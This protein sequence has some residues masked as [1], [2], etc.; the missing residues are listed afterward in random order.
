MMKTVW[1]DTKEFLEQK[2][3]ILPLILTATLSYGFMAVT[4]TIGI[5]DTASERFFQEGLE[6][7]MGRWVLFLINKVFSFAEFAPFIT[8]VLGVIFMIISVTLWCV[9]FKRI[10]GNKIPILGYTFFSCIFISAPI[11]SE[12]FTYYTH[13]GIG[14]A[15]GLAAVGAI[16]FTEGMKGPV[17]KRWKSLII[18]AL[19]AA[20]A[21]GCYESMV[22]V[23]IMGI[24]MAYLFL[25]KEESGQHY[26]RRLLWW[27]FG[28]GISVILLML[29]RSLLI[30]II[31]VVFQ[32]EK[33]ILVLPTRGIS[34]AF[35]WVNGTKSMGEFTMVLKRF[36]LKYYI[37]ALR[38][39]PI[40]M[41]VIAALILMI[42][43]C[44]QTIRYRKPVLLFCGCAILLIP[45]V[46][47]LIEAQVTPYRASQYIPLVCGFAVL[48]L[49]DMIQE[50]AKGRFF[51]PLWYVAVIWMTVCTFNQC[52]E[53]NKWFYVDHLKYEDAKNTMNTIAYELENSYD[54]E[55]PIIFVGH[56]RVPDGMLRD[57]GLK[58]NAKEFW[59][60]RACSDILDPHLKEKYY[61]ASGYY[62]LA[63]T[64][65]LSV[66]NWGVSAFD[67]TN[68]E[69][70][71]FLKMH[72][73]EF[74]METDLKRYEQAEK[75]AEDR[76]MPSWPE[77]G[78]IQDAEEYIIVKLGALKE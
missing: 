31:K 34:E 29:V 25:C 16:A 20:T 53:M 72:G 22:I 61:T 19:F 55:K 1:E 7:Y 23:Y 38:Y 2:I 77:Q 68:V 35:Q 58:L 78:Y 47:I 64:P 30:G 71:Q 62:K 9:V 67:R 69:L 6:P 12:L 10:L 32:L 17:S 5:D 41:F 57:A 43:C 33:N 15:Y 46:M 56:Y 4:P 63:E 66:L 11:L 26:D 65:Y 37:N 52:T 45:W 24:V 36:F 51:Q 50:M 44:V 14:M 8:E 40:T 21:A 73:H 76:N 42:Y 59:S 70:F 74:R 13:N 28:G 3:Y 75:Q 60:I 39:F 48:L 27:L 54:I 18:S 49:A